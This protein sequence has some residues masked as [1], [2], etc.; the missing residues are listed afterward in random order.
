MAAPAVSLHEMMM[1]SMIVALLLSLAA[2]LALALEK[3]KRMKTETIRPT[4][5]GFV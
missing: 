2:S 4:Q 5:P 1:R 3:T